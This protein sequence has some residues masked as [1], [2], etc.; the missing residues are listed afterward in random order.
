M[1]ACGFLRNEVYM[2]DRKYPL[3][4]FMMGFISNMLFRYWFILLLAI[5][6]LFIGI[7]NENFIRLGI[8]FLGVDIGLSLVEQ[9]RIRK[10]ILEESDNPDF[11]EFQDAVLS[12][13]WKQNVKDMVESKIQEEN[14]IDE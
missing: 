5:I 10:T 9:W 14:E 2:N 8:I 1:N 11:R 6:L 13:D 7:W 12:G 4:L 3:S